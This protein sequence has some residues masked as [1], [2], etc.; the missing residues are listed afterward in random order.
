MIEYVNAFSNG[1]EYDRF[2]ENNCCQCKLWGVCYARRTLERASWGSGIITKQLYDRIFDNGKCKMYSVIKP[3]ARKKIDE[4]Q[5][6]L[7]KGEQDE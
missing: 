3:I 2:T 6:L 7:F 4:R 5:E 1:A